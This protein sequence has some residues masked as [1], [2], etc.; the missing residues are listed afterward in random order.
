MG[1]IHFPIAYIQIPTVIQNRLWLDGR[2]AGIKLILYSCNTLSDPYSCKSADT[3]GLTVSRLVREETRQL[4]ERVYL[5]G[6]KCSKLCLEHI[7]RVLANAANVI[8]V[9]ACLP[10]LWISGN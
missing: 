5:S 10:S 2:K 9:M 7:R 8:I 6:F 3:R 1:A 4:H